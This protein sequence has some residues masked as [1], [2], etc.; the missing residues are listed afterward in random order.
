VDAHGTVLIGGGAASATAA[1]HTL[2][3][4]GFLKAEVLTS[5]YCGPAVVKPVT[6]AFTLPTGLGRVVSIPLSPADASGVPPCLGA[7]GSA[8]GI[9]MHAWQT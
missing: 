2:H 1:L 5:N 7:P 9:S 8:G 3:G 6:L 4:L